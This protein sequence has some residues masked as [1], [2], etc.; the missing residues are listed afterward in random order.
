MLLIT[1]A[2]PVAPAGA[3]PPPETRQRGG[4]TLTVFAA[5]SL[6]EAFRGAAAEFSAANPGTSFSFNFAGSQQLAQQIVL[7]ARADVFAS[8]DMRQMRAAGSMI[9]SASIRVFVRN[10]LVVVVPPSPGRKVRHLTDLAA[11]GVKIVLAA[12]AVPAG[13]YALRFIGEC[14]ASPGFPAGFRSAVMRNVVSYEEN[15]RAVL[16]K[17]VLAEADA[18]I[19]YVTD[20]A[21]VKNHGVDTVDIPGRLNVLAEYPVGRA[22]ES[23]HPAEAEQFIRFLLSRRG[24]E[25]LEQSGFTRAVEPADGSGVTPAARG[26]TPHE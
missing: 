12:D 21:S 20:A 6:N 14:A 5:A 22:R 25:I 17:V 1:G 24:Q 11:A 13:E 8:A 3:P 4:I 23:A 9:D 7:G 19:V 16:A 15:V 10:R 2:P 26:I 18:G